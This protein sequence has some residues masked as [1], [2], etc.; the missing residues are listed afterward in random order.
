MNRYLVWTERYFD[1][2]KKPI[3][4]K[5]YKKL[6]TVQ[7]LLLSTIMLKHSQVK[8]ISHQSGATAVEFVFALLALLFFFGIFMQFVQIFIAGERLSIAAFSASRICAVQGNGPALQ[9]ALSIEP[10][11]A[12]EIRQREIVMTRDVV[13]PA[14]IDMFM[15][16]GERRFTVRHSSPLFREPDIFDDNQVNLN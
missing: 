1:L 7:L 12:I 16:G 4:T 13:I 14:G 3:K 15:T 5:Y 11:A 2:P 9:T 8:Y 10:Q 6:L